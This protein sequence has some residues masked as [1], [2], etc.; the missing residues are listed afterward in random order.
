MNAK[1][2]VN[3]KSVLGEGPLW[4]PAE[5][6]LYWVDIEGL[7]INSI[8]T[9]S[10]KQST[11]DFEKRPGAVV[12]TSDGKF[13]IAF[14]DGLALYDWSTKE[15]AYKDKLGSNTPMVRAN[16]GKC[17][18]DGNFWI[19]TMHLELEEGAG[20][21]YCYKNDFVE[22]KVLEN[23]TVSNGLAWTSDGKTMYYIDSHDNRMMAY[24]YHNGAITNGRVAFTIDAEEMGVLD[25]MAIDAEDKL[26]IAHWGGNCVRRWDPISGK[27][28]EKVEVAAPHVTSCC[29]GGEKMDELYIT[30]ATIGLSDE[31]FAE[32]PQSGGVFM[33][34]PGV[35]GPPADI[36]K[37]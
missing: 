33:I 9:E 7:K 10:Q 8:H 25:G 21:L 2:I 6:S 24:D 12:P 27:V 31:Q 36:F 14:E 32:Y 13:L 30:T 20:A 19:G 15:L 3:A 5:K 22:N 1:L 37:S 29:F 28:L 26:W 34:K 4:M 35:S 16:D 18:P 11:H 23:R 17:D